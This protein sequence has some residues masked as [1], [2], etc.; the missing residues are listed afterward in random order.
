MCAPRPTATG[1]GHF[2]FLLG[3][4]LIEENEGIGLSQG[5]DIAGSVLISAALMLGVYAIV[6]AAGQGW[7]SAH[8]L[9][10]GGASLALLAGFVVVESRVKN[11][12]MP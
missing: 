10:F 9:G 11:P 4:W 3:W 1:P 2:I 7:T 5:V 8:T 12:I 6:T